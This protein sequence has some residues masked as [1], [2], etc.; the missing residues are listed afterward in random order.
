MREAVRMYFLCT[1]AC[2]VFSLAIIHFLVPLL[3]K[4]AA[5]DRIDSLIINDK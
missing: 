5:E 1:L 2:L 4:R 3:E